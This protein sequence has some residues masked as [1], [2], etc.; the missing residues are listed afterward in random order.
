MKVKTEK[1]EL[2]EE[3]EESLILADVGWNSTQ[4]II[5]SI[6]EKIRVQFSPE[7]VK[8]IIE[9]EIVSILTKSPI[10]L[11]FGKSKTVIM[12]VGVNGS[13]KT[14]CTAKLANYLKKRKMKV[15]M[16]AADTF[17]PAAIEQLLVWGEKIGVPVFKNYTAKD[18]ASVVFDAL[19]IKDVDVF[20]ID[21]GG[22]LHT[23]INLMQEV[24]KI[25]RICARQVKGAPHDVLLVLD[26]G[27]GQNAIQQAREFLKFTGL[28]GIFVSK[29]DGTAKGGCVIGISDELGLPVKFI[30]VGEG[31]D[32]IMEFSPEEYA[33]ALLR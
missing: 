21:T 1:E 7:E 24:E 9:N 25:A 12:L 16:V 17:R 20:L 32:D 2:I 13:G 8:R 4:K 6:R 19:K 11:N 27:I 15:I 10:N 5:N 26:A 33:R 14:T 22:R 29:L 31:E 30:G 23:K 18:P 3:I 28:T